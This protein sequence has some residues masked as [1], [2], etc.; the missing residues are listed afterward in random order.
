MSKEKK[1]SEIRIWATVV[2]IYS[3]V[4]VSV[5]GTS[6]ELALLRIDSY[7]LALLISRK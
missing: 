1:T 7:Q 5:D 3:N 6:D 4:V 2:W